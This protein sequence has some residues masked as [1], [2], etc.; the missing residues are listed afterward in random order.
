MKEDS[1]SNKTVLVTGDV[2]A[3]HNI[4]K[5]WRNVPDSKALQGTM[6]IDSPGGARLLHDVVVAVSQV[7]GKK[8][9][10][11]YDVQFGLDTYGACPTKLHSYAVWAPCRVEGGSKEMVWRLVEPMGYGSV[12]AEVN[13]CELRLCKAVDPSANVIVLDDAALGFRFNTAKDAWPRVVRDGVIDAPDWVVLKMSNPVARGD[14]WMQLRDKFSEK[15]VLIV[16][17][18]DIRREEVSVTK[19]LSWENT[20]Q[21]LISELKFNSRIRDLM[22]CRHLIINFRSEGA[23]WVD[24]N[25]TECVYRLIFDPVNL[26][27]EWGDKFEGRVFGYTSCL[28][29]GVINQLVK[30]GDKMDIGAGIIS[31][32]SAM[33]CLH[34]IGHGKVEDHKP[35]FPFSVV[36]EVISGASG[37]G[38]YSITEFP[39]PPDDINS[40]T[41]H[42]TIMEGVHGDGG[43]YAR[44]LY[45]QARKVALSGPQELGNIPYARFGKLFTVDRSEIESLRSIQHLIMDYEAKPSPSR[46]L[47]IAVFGTPGSGKSFATKQ[48]ATAIFGKDEPVLEFNLSQFHDTE[49]LTFAF[50]QVRDKVLEG[51]TPIVFWD[52][53]DSEDLKWLRYLLAPMQD[54]RFMEGQINHPIGK[55]IFVFAG[56]TSFDM[57]SFVPTKEEPERYKDFKRIKG[58]DF[59][60]RLSGYLNVLGPNKRRKYDRETKNWV[61]DQDPP[62][63]YFPVRRALL[64]RVSLGL[65]KDEKLDIDKGL[66]TAFLEIDKYKHGS[67]SIEAIASLSRRYVSRGFRRSDLPPADQMSLHVDYD[68]FMGLVNRDLSFKLKSESLAPAIHNYYRQLCNKEGKPVKY[69]MDYTELPNEVQADNMAAAVRIQEILNI[70]GLE[71]VPESY[72]GASIGSKGLEY[73]IELLAEAEHN[74]WKQGTQHFLIPYK[75]QSDEEKEK[76]RNT[77]RCYPEIVK[78]ADYKIVASK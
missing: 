29:S 56:G 5:G 34:K 27:G 11:E 12:E 26:E 71:V 24:N 37:C 63:I 40:L 35:A 43:G 47:S 55:C 64:L 44:P 66:L 76:D 53:F 69:N 25:G 30:S 73:S 9:Q 46:P 31:G 51:R 54:G 4:Y 22:K 18:N 36:A 57:A 20:V 49:E 60:S 8:K 38:K 14:L 48:I 42:W 41:S 62:D 6:I 72:P 61:D 68:R 78:M 65:C 70:A 10:A 23:L 52:E 50:H 59:V 77:V 3:D 13:M 16:S 45:G 32:L 19:G 74:G 2:I 75:D 28:V 67:R 1:S 39:T 33:R 17:V 58:P 7:A 21:G 15:L